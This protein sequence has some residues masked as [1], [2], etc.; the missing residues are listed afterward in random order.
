MAAQPIQVLLVETDSE[1]ARRLQRLLHA[2]ASPKFKARHVRRL[3]DAERLLEKGQIGVALLNLRLPSARTMDFLR[4]AQQ[5]SPEVPLVLLSQSVDEEL[6]AEALRQGAQD[7]LV[8]RELVDGKLA[9]ALSYAIG[10]QRAQ[11]SLHFLS[12]I[13]ELTS[14]HNR[15]GF[16]TLA[17]Q[18]LKLTRRRGLRSSLVFIDLDDLKIINDTYGH[19]E[20]DCALQQTARVLRECFR[21]SD[22]VARVGGDEFCALLQDASRSG[23]EAVRD[24]LQRELDAYNDSSEKPYRVSVSVGI[25]ELAGPEGFEHDI[26]RADALMYA[27]KRSKQ[28]QRHSFAIA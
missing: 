20:G 3:R 25:V 15:R 8:K 7:F 16:V 9:R 4:R 18:Q 10:R 5:R 26:A 24:R 22:I 19:R 28:K 17:E 14:L 23:E 12:L 27:Q 21:D 6:A 13:D 1:D 2:G 11:A